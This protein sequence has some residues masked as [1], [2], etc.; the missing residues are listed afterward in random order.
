MADLLP[1]RIDEAFVPVRS[2]TVYTVEIDGEAVLLD[3]SENRIHH[4]NHSA[5]CR[6]HASTVT[7]ACTPA[8]GHEELSAP[9]PLAE[10]QSVAT[11]IAGYSPGFGRLPGDA[12]A[13]A[14]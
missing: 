2:A 1:E 12:E 3:E 13:E 14:P 11:S 4:L 7:L 8:C 10:A 9:H 6:L 5:A